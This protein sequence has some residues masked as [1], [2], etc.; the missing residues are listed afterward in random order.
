MNRMVL[1]PITL[2]RR[3]PSS[4]S[5]AGPVYV[6]VVGDLAHHADFGLADL[7]DARIFKPRQR[8]RVR[9]VGVKHRLGLRQR[10]VDRR[11]DA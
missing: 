7:L 8:A 2:A 1:S 5:K 6:V 11:M 3:S 9:H 4:G 10:I